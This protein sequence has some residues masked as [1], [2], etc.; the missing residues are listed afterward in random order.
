MKLHRIFGITLRYLYAFRHSWDRLSDVFYWPAMDLFLW[1]LTSTY[2]RLYAPHASNI[3]LMIVS[4]LLFW[5]IIWRAQYEITVNM[6]EEFWNKNLVNIFVSPLKFSEWVTSFIVIGIIKGS[7]SFGFAA[8]LAFFLYRM[9]IFVYG[10]YLLPFFLLLFMSGW[11]VGFFVAGIIIQY[12]TKIQTLAWAVVA[13]IAPFSGIYYP[14][15]ILPKWAQFISKFI[16]TSYIFEGGR[17]A[18]ATGHVNPVKLYM[19]FGLNSLYIVLA[20]IF[21]RYSFKKVFRKGL[22][23]VI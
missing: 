10:W 16:P 1:G 23:S 11:A 15:S 20:L 12:G 18:L 2:I 3:V 6:L 22:A 9:G 17:E 5:L 14:L 7:I 21:L 19:S 8:T 4:G 13:V